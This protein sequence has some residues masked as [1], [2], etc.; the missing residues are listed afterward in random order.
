MGAS[1]M[2][3][4]TV[5]PRVLDARTRLAIRAGSW[6]L[7]LLGATWRI[8]VHGWDDYAARHARGEPV[9][10]ALWHGQ[11]LSCTYA[12]KLPI[13][14]MVSEHRDGE[15]I[16]QIL[17]HF[18]FAAVRGSSS[19]GG[20]RA[21][22]EAAGIVKGGSDV[23]I[24]P[25]GPRGPRHSFAPGALALAFRSGVPL[26]SLV[27]HAN[28]SWRLKS[29][30]SF[31]IPKPFARIDVVYSAPMPVPGADIREATAH[32]PQFAEFMRAELTR[33]ASIATTARTPR[34]PA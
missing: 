23:A 33:A 30:D 34:T 22:L 3:P 28:R 17:A 18:G 5:P 10:L 13:A 16:A 4:A 7:K 12:H 32:A 19:R 31:E 25:D 9:V 27:S 1:R 11:M 20:A 14:V 26:V 8:R 15:I 21:L 24:T 29:W 2:P 6:L